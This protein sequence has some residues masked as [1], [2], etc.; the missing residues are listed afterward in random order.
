MDTQDGSSDFIR[1]HHVTYCLHYNIYT[2][3]LD[4][5]DRWDFFQLSPRMEI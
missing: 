1:R 4:A 3:I 2:Y 5:W